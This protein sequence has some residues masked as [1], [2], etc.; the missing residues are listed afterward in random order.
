VL[1]V[2]VGTV[3]FGFF[4]VVDAGAALPKH[5]SGDLKQQVSS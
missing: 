1:L 2:A 4:G 5:K 3:F